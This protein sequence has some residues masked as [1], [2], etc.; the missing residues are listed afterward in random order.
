MGNR[1]RSSDWRTRRGEIERK[2]NRER[3]E[4]REVK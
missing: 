1:S 4:Y 2:E 3:G